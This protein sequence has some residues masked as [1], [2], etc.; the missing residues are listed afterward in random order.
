MGNDNIK[1]YITKLQ[2]IESLPHDIRKMGRIKEVIN[3]EEKISLY[4]GQK[5]VAYIDREIEYTN[6]RYGK[7]HIELSDEHYSSLYGYIKKI[8]DN[9]SHYFHTPAVNLIKDTKV[10]QAGK[11]FYGGEETD[12]E[13][14]TQNIFTN[15][16]SDLK[17]LQMF[18]EDEKQLLTK[19]R[20]KCKIDNAIETILKY[21]DDPHIQYYLGRIE[22]KEETISKPLLLSSFFYHYTMIFLKVHELKKTQSRELS[23]EIM[24][25]IFG[26]ETDYRIL[27]NTKEIKYR[28]SHFT[29]YSTKK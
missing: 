24:N 28:D 20:D 1:E 17:I 19:K 4:F 15:I 5:T 2:E 21:T 25:D 12:R 10:Y 9:N 18:E 6:K 26:A 11:A 7:S 8:K 16:I 14:R 22:N 29:Y 3:Q 27:K 13:M 23:A